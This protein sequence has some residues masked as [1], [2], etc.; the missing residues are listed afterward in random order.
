MTLY[1]LQLAQQFALTNIARDATLEKEVLGSICLCSFCSYR[2]MHYGAIG[3][4]ESYIMAQ[5][6]ILQAPAVRQGDSAA[7]DV[8]ALPSF[9]PPTEVPHLCLEA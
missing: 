2:L 3:C 6:I 4:S 7:M 5:A 9:A 8:H 1:L